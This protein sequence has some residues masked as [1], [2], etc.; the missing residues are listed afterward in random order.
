VLLR[1]ERKAQAGV[2]VTLAWRFVAI[3]AAGAAGLAVS[4]AHRV[5]GAS[6][7]ARRTGRDV[8]VRESLRRLFALRDKTLRQRGIYR[9]MLHS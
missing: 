6:A 5:A 2:P 3:D 8:R 9:W 4:A 7:A 1:A